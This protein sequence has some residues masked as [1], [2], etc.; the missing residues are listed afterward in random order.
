MATIKNFGIVG[1]GSAVQ[2]GKGGGKV[3]Y[4]SGNSLFKV[5]NTAGDLERLEVKLPEG[6]SDAATKGYVDSVAQGLDVKESVRVATNQAILIS[7]PGAMI[8]GVQLAQGDRVLV[9]DQAAESLTQ[10]GIY[11]FDTSATPMV[12]ATDMDATGEFT[13]SFFFVEQGSVNSDQGFVCSSIG[14]VVPG[15]T[16]VTFTQ[17]TGT[18][19]ISAGQGLSK[20]GN[21]ISTNVDGTFIKVDGNDALTINGTATTGEVLKSDGNGG[22]TYGTVNL[23]S[24]D[25]VAGVLP[26]ANGGL[27]VSITDAASKLTA[28]TSL[29][30]QD[31]STQAAS[32]V[33]I[34]GGTIADT[35]TIGFAND[36][37]SGD[38]VDG[39]TISD[40]NLAGSAGNTLNGYDITVG[41]LKTLDV[42]GI[43]DVD[44]A[45][46]SAIDNVTIGAT[47]SAAGTFS[48]L[49]TDSVDLN[50]GNIDG[51][52]IGGTTAAAG[53]FTAM[54][55]TTAKM[56]TV[57][58]KAADGTVT[59]NSPIN[60][61]AGIEV[62]ALE[63]PVVT[64]DAIAEKTPGNGVD[65]DGLAIQD[66]GLTATTLS[67]FSSVDINGGNIDA[68]AINESIIGA[69]VSAAGTFS[70]MTSADAQ[71]TGGDI[72]ANINVSAHTLTLADNQISGDKIDGG[73]ISDFASTG[74]DD[75]ATALQVTIT[76]A[77]TTVN[78]DL[79]VAGNLSVTG[80]LTSI[81]TANTTISD[82]I[83]VL[84]DG[85]TGDGVSAGSAGF[86]IDRGESAPG[87]A[88]DA[89]TFTWNEALDVFEL[90]LGDTL[91][92][93]KVSAL[94]MTGINV[95][96]IAA[97][98]GD[99]V[100]FNDDIA[101]GDAGLTGTLSVDTISES[102]ANVGVTVDSVLLKDG[103]VTA[104]L[105]AEA[106][107]TVDVSAATFVLADNQISGDKVEGGTIAAITITSLSATSAD[108]DGGTIDGTII[109]GT[110]AVAGTFSTMTTVG[111]D[112]TGG[113]I[114]GTTIGLGTDN[115]AAG[116]FSTMTTASAAITGGAIDG[117][118]IGGTTPS[119]GTFATMNTVNA[120]ITGGAI[121]GASLTSSEVD[122]NGGAMDAV[123]IGANTSAAGTFSTM[124]TASAA[125]T[126]G[127][128]TGMTNVAATNL[129]SGNATITGGSI[130]GTDIN[131]AGVTLTFDADQI[132]GNAVH[133]GTISDA[134]LVGATAGSTMSSYDIT[135]GAGRSLDVSAGTLTLANNQISGDKVDGGSISNFASTGID[136]NA[137][138][139]KVTVTDA[140]TTFGHAIDAGAN[141]ITGGAGTLASLTVSGNTTI[142]GDLTVSG[143]V[144]TTLAET[145]NIEDNLIVL[146][147]NFTGAATENAGIEVERGDD[148]NK[149]FIWDETANRWST[150][151]EDLAIGTLHSDSFALTGQVATTD[152]GTGTD[153]SGFAEKSFMVMNADGTGVTELAKGANS[154]V[155]KVNAS[156]TLGYAKVDL[157]AD[158]SGIA[159]IANGG[160]G[161]AT[162]GAEHQVLVADAAGALAYGYAG[163]LRNATGELAVSTAGM[164]AAGNEYLDIA[165]ATG[166][167]IMTAKNASGTGL[168]DMYLQGQNGGDVFLVGND[169]EAVL[170]GDD[171][172]DLTVS[173]GNS[174]LAEAGDLVLKGGNGSANGIS[175]DVVLKGG[176]GGSING[177]TIVMGANDTAI[178]TFV[179]TSSSATDS[180]EIKNGTGGV[181]LAAAGGTD[182]NLTLSPKGTGAIMAKAGTVIDFATADDMTLATKVYVDDEIEKLSDNFLRQTFTASGVDT[183]TVGSLKNV[184]DKVYYVKAVTIKITTAFVG[185]DEIVVTDGVNELVGVDDTDM[186]DAGFFI[187]E[188]GYETASAGGATITAT[189][190]QGGVA[191]VPTAGSVVVAVEY[192]QLNA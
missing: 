75:N 185:V 111:A 11:V 90:K 149:Q 48:S 190:K 57:T 63:A 25:A 8:D 106:G 15:S 138:A 91:A 177:K 167:V 77:L 151:G 114:T 59:F 102:T 156:G 147:S 160:T 96:T 30:L 112:I 117:T 89:A 186:S 41:A 122:L 66:G 47:T 128:A 143:A 39:G 67:T 159:P 35:V 126:G 16:D 72:A 104:G 13:G 95:N 4:D 118:I 173:G 141:A 6:E 61:A 7:A 62:S 76:D 133:G 172:N 180:L 176:V 115:S 110:S 100:T 65:V 137:T 12:R 37:I 31:M 101:G 56:D 120:V 43:L 123:I 192:K 154:T 105:T 170:Q 188:Q 49:T 166:R 52:V 155:L 24:S 148:A 113:T 129:S 145:V 161:L 135:V 45:A 27:G 163:N 108:I 79:T 83:I 182:V 73:V 68:T 146:N 42:D 55:T 107:D 164:T 10:N 158:V 153:V 18:G 20:V 121:S 92:D 58:S 189:F 51:T 174:D 60:A 116:T 132:S 54:H 169:G 162:A 78:N 1:I 34:T 23:A 17:F 150:V 187:I 28:R 22:V 119:T 131:L 168:V 165:N 50:G 124:T 125:I 130:S 44:G 33:N 46:G 5:T 21:T 40:A 171:D 53:T 181:E 109:G 36:A 94:A 9:K 81:N 127:N 134:N 87:V 38:K 97:L 86:S 32:A 70:T 84:N 93:L 26:L 103:V 74:I 136:D 85:E 14:T 71:I 184:A 19:Q 29:G 178:A 144:T 175:G 142:Q 179:E 3:V 64:T 191:V 88:N 99:V 183:F 152:G 98:S 157:T 80:T 82:N 139:T 2:Y 140:K 69:T